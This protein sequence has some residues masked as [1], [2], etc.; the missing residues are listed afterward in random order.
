VDGAGHQFFA[1]AALALN[2]DGG[3]SR[4]H[5]GD[6][7]IHLAHARAFADHAVLNADLLL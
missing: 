7:L 4:R 5:A 6:K 3:F 2:Q 1:G